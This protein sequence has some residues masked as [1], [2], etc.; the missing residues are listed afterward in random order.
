MSS[1]RK[2]VSKKDCSPEKERET[3]ICLIICQ[4][5]AEAQLLT[6]A[7]TTFLPRLAQATRS[8]L[9]TRQG[10]PH[11]NQPTHHRAHKPPHHSRNLIPLQRPA[12]HEDLLA[13]CSRRYLRCVESRVESLFRI[14][15]RQHDVHLQLVADLYNNN[16]TSA[17]HTPR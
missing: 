1:M 16:N 6:N 3:I 13:R 2:E 8:P 14:G 15:A 7:A 17:T 9:L 11:H 4:K 5:R 10:S 12:D